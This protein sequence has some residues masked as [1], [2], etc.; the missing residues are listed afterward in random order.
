M[1]LI[2]GVVAVVTG[3]TGCAGQGLR[4]TITTRG[5]PV[6]HASSALVGDARMRT[7]VSR[8][9]VLGGMTCRAI[10][11]KHACMKG[12]IRMAADAGG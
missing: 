10:R 6:I 1:A 9:P 7:V 8:E 3:E 4:V 2:V 12:R 11:A 5:A